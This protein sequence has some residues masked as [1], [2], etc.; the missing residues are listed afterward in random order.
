MKN[1]GWVLERREKDLQ[2]VRHEFLDSSRSYCRPLQDGVETKELS[3]E[4]MAQYMLEAH[5]K[6]YTKV[7]PVY[8]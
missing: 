1:I 3:A 2:G 7:Y 6:D 8:V 4:Q 5:P